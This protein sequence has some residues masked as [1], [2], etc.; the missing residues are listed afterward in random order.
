METIKNKLT[1]PWF[2]AQKKNN[3]TLIEFLIVISIIA[4]LAGM[5]LPVLNRVRE[6]AQTIHCTSNLKQTGVALYGY[7]GD[8]MDFLPNPNTN[9][10]SWGG[11]YHMITIRPETP[12]NLASYLG[13]PSAQRPAN[14]PLICPVARTKITHTL[15]FGTYSYT[16]LATSNFQS[17]RRWAYLEYKGSTQHRT[18]RLANMYSN[19]ALLYCTK[20]FTSGYVSNN[21]EGFGNKSENVEELNSYGGIYH[22]RQLVLLFGDGGTASVK[23]PAMRLNPNTGTY[24]IYSWCI[25]R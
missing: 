9:L 15:W 20:P 1:E 2:Q 21:I 24:S 10:N 17:K 23:I 22:T 18:P 4:I 5:L 8:N 12:S 16:V 13:H 19:L 14:N 6:K 25:K 11:S 3:F 7:A